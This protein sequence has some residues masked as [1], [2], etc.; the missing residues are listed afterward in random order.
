MGRSETGQKALFSGRFARLSPAVALWLCITPALAQ[1]ATGDDALPL[2]RGTA[3]GASVAVPLPADPLQTKRAPI[4]YGKPK[5]APRLLP[6]TPGP[7]NIHPLPALQPYRTAPG[8]RRRNPSIAA[9]PPGPTVAAIPEI[10]QPRRSAVESDPYAPL[11]I[12][13]GSLRLTPYVESDIG[14]D[15]NP[16]RATANVKS[17]GFARAEAGVTAQSNWS[18]HEFDATLK[19]GYSDYFTVK[20]ASRPDVSAVANAR[21]DAT[22]DLAFDL[23]GRLTLDSQNTT[24]PGLLT[25]TTL[26]ARPLTY[27]SGGSAGVTEK[28]NR[29]TLA[30]RGSIDRYAYEDASLAGG[31]TLVLS[32][33][34]YNDFGLRGRAA[35]EITPGI[36][37]FVDAT[38][39]A[40]RYD[41]R[42]DG[43]GFAR[44]SDGFALKAGSSFELSRVL[45]GEIS[46]GYG[47]RSYADRR[48]ADLSSPVF[49]ASLVWT[50]SPLTK[51]TLRGATDIAESSLA[52][53]SGALT[54]R[55]SLEVAHSLMRNFTLTGI[56]SYTN[57]DYQGVNLRENL[58]SGTVRAEYN[59][60]RSIVIRSSFT[61]ER[62]KSTVPGADYTANTVLLGLRLQQ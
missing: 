46:G 58:Y 1:T 25:G 48:L 20:D 13:A 38:V 9:A 18:A 10:V 56:A 51:V 15:S 27:A 57:T 21:I 8:Q 19:G 43:S 6:K 24:T 55:V 12:D 22:R 32:K 16:R 39:D 5:K 40:R 11:G 29:L 36:S 33:Q 35:Y 26:S 47:H 62:L 2:I 59:L 54:R 7:Q 3:A 28:I 4:N 37:P 14:Y 49:D 50:A 53:A 23:Q 42:L 52:N 41:S 34:D 61:H 45:T 44:N 17:S 30:L 31:Q 60:T